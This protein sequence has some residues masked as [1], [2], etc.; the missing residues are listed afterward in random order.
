MEKKQIIILVLAL[1]LVLVIL[2]YKNKESFYANVAPGDIYAVKSHDKCARAYE[3][4]KV[5]NQETNLCIKERENANSGIRNIK[6]ETADIISDVNDNSGDE[7]Y[8]PNKSKYIGCIK[9]NKHDKFFV[10]STESENKTFEQ[11]KEKGSKFFGSSIPK[12]TSQNKNNYKKK[13]FDDKKL[14][15]FTFGEDIPNLNSSLVDDGKCDKIRDSDNRFLGGLGYVAL[16]QQDNEYQGLNF[17]SSSLKRIQ[18]YSFQDI[19]QI[20]NNMFIW[21]K[22]FDDTSNTEIIKSGLKNEDGKIVE[23]QNGFNNQ[24]KYILKDYSGNENHAELAHI[25]GLGSYMIN[26]KILEKKLITM[27]NYKRIIKAPKDKKL[28]EIIIRNNRVGDLEE[29]E[30]VSKSHYIDYKGIDFGLSIKNTNGEQDTFQN[31]MINNS[32]IAKWDA[33]EPKNETLEYLFDKNMFVQAKNVDSFIS[34]D[35]GN[36]R[37]KI[38]LKELRIYP[39]IDG[40]PGYY[41]YQLIRLLNGLTIKQNCVGR[42]NDINRRLPKID[43][44]QVKDYEIYKNYFFEIQDKYDIKLNEYKKDGKDLF[45]ISLILNS[46]TESIEIKNSIKE[47]L[48]LLYIDFSFED[49]IKNK[50]YNSMIDLHNEFQEFETIIPYRFFISRFK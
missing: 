39:R 38:M 9:K 35:L 34:I 46:Y 10:D 7:F 15:C 48:E 8:I 13:I 26:N 40:P 21:Y 47:R 6:R 31:Y 24:K 19:E 49:L 11:C 17:N 25:K 36:I 4:I 41:Y 5:R 32:I 44:Q 28:K 3:N 22:T 45:Y 42:R 43:Y 50:F 29:D 20:R 30:E 33:R 16:Y 2:L 37:N 12:F 18:K 14:N 1:A 23:I 27:P